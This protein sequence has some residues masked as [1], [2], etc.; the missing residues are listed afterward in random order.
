MY[1]KA[2][3]WCLSDLF[4]FVSSFYA[5][6]IRVVDH[7]LMLIL[8]EMDLPVYDVRAGVLSTL[9]NYDLFVYMD[10]YCGKTMLYCE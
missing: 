4:L 8:N 7:L 6:R 1:I 5:T 2:R 3:K 10:L 9:Y